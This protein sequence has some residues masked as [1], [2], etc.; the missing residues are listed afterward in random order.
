MR[1]AHTLAQ[2]NWARNYPDNAHLPARLAWSVISH[3]PLLT[4]E[5]QGTRSESWV[6]LYQLVSQNTGSQLRRRS[7]FIHMKD[8]PDSRD[9][10]ECRMTNN[11]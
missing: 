8:D 1:I 2:L 5:T 10:C 4:F 9:K 3:P 6:S 7:A 11:F